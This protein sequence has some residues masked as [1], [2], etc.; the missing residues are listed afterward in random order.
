VSWW[1]V[2]LPRCRCGVPWG[3]HGNPA[4]WGCARY[5]PQL[6]GWAPQVAYMALTRAADRCE[7]AAGWVAKRWLES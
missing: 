4:E 7:A 1:W 6:R 5:R 3:E 2:W